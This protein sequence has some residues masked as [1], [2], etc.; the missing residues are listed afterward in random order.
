MK[1]FSLYIIAMV[2]GLVSV[3]QDEL[4]E[5]LDDEQGEEYVSATFKST[6]LINGHNVEVRAPKVLEFVIS[7]RFGRLNGGSQQAYGLDNATIRLGLEYGLAKNLN[8]GIGRA[9]LGK[10]FDTFLKYR[11]IRQSTSFPITV[12]A[13]GSM[14]YTSDRA[15]VVE[16]SDQRYNYTGQLLIARK[17][18]Q[19]LSLQ[20]M[21]T[22]IYR[23]LVP[24]NDDAN[25]LIALGMG[26]RYKVS[27]RVAINIEY[28]PQLTDYNEDRYDVVAFGVD[29][30]TGG[31]VFQLHLTNAEQMNEKGFI[32]ETRDD[33]SR[34][35]LH[36][37]FNISRVFHLGAKRKESWD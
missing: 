20:L 18:N 11:A 7:H 4:L 23:P 8:L 33:I 9:S 6:R 12:T 32:G 17:F 36:F 24:T 1:K 34:G 21:P 15:I 26:G 30:E 22:M 37:G 19:N 10:T 35:Q 5:L 27:N 29:I 14:A 31:H 3:A 28:Y 25:T 13:F 2:L 16:S